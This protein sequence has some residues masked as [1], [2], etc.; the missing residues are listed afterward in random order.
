MVIKE[1]A[2]DWRE[3]HAD[4]LGTMAE[5]VSVVK[6]GDTVYAGGWTSVPAQLCHALIDRTNLE[7]VNV[8]TYLTPVNWDRPEVL[9][10]FHITT[11]YAAPYERAAA[12]QGRFD[13]VPVAQFREGVL[14]PGIDVPIDVAMIPISPPDE[15]GWCSFGGGVWFGP[16][17]ASHAKT[18]I[19]EVH[20][21]FIRTGGQN[22]IHVSRFARLAEI[23][24]TPPPPPIPPRSE[25]T[26]LAAQVICTL[27][28]TEIVRDGCTLQFGVGDVSAAMPLFLTEKR[29]LGVHTEIC[30]GGIAELVKQGVVTGEHKTLHPGKVV[31]SALVQMPPDELAYIN[32]NETFELYDFTHTD[33]L[34][35]LLRL[36]N[37]IAINIALA[38]VLSGYVSSESRGS[39]LWCG[40]G[41]Q[42][43]F[44]V[45][46]STTSGGSVIVLPSSQLVD[47]TRHPRIVGAH[48][49]GTV[50]TVHRGFVD[51]VVTEQ[52]VA[53]LRGKSLRGR[54]GELIS[55]AHP[56]HRA[57]LR[58]AA[59]RLYGITV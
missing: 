57:E 53:W 29:G 16:S 36:D 34:R 13:Y 40:P 14:P 3:R 50:V 38:V 44:A 47:G 15:E 39:A 25:E 26:E 11:F 42:P 8:L 37:F 35:N 32:G 24:G 58:Q 28:A 10:R 12:Q 45:A 31:A 7:N 46:S 21:G 23:T 9:E 22:R 1:A 20:P 55:V 6:S 48:E 56:D 27:V 19:G 5:A 17:V 2:A 43:S 18:L 59:A 49:P 51:Y 33:D 30:P 41:G 52:G 4:K 54:I